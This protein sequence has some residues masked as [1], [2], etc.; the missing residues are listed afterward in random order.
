MARIP[1][2]T[3]QQVIEANDI[4][5][6]ISGYLP[7]LK[8]SG[9]AFKACC[10]FH[11]EKTPSFTVN[12]GRQSFKCFGCGEG[13]SVVGF[14]MK[15]E[16]LPFPDA[17][18]KL[19]SRANIIIREEKEDPQA[20]QLRKSRSRLIEIHNQFAVFLHQL[21]L[22]SKES[23]HARDYLNSRGY[24]ADMAKGWKIGWIPDHAQHVFRW[25]KDNGFTA[26]DLIRCGLAALKDETMPNRGIYL[27]FR[28]RLMFPIHNEYG[29]VI[30]F[31]GRQLRE[32][33]RSGKYVNSPE[34]E[35]FI[36]SKV[37]FGLDKARRA[38]AKQGHAL[39]CEG[40]LDVIAC[41]EAGIET[42]VA[43]Q[44]TA[45]TPDHIR[46]LKRYTKTIILCYDADS[47]GVK[48][49]QSAFIECARAGLNVKVITL[50]EGSDPDT[51]LKSDGTEAFQEKINSA[52]DFFDYKI[53]SSA[54]QLDLNSPSEKANFTAEIASLLTEM[55]DPLQLNACIDFAATRIGIPEEEL[56]KVSQNQ[57]RF[58][59]NVPNSKP[60]EEQ[61]YTLT[62]SVPIRSLCQL[63]LYS[64]EAYDWMQEQIEPL[65]DAI[66][67]E[68]GREALEHLIKYQ[69][70]PV[71]SSQILSYLETLPEDLR[72]AFTQLS[73]E[74][75]TEYAVSS[76]QE[77]FKHLSVSNLERELKIKIQ[78]LDKIPDQSAD[79]HTL[80]KEILDL[81]KF[82]GEIR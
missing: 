11:S 7:D 67:R 12:P 24:G 70:R 29:D 47:A 65:F 9:S 66:E 14:V 3:I 34:T 74:V 64:P 73:D 2:E 22:K 36:K 54:A 15:H 23:Q 51:Y 1:E 71:K 72:S 75:Q 80:Q 26:K 60:E 10:P 18:R 58:K 79:L 55:T 30:G 44:G 16:N 81:Q 32:D 19:A 17:V 38:I 41:H 77:I 57:K 48:A 8:R 49:T 76:A 39:L 63:S 46:I 69:P 78:K 13:G 6:V 28:D 5:E 53:A 59:R 21:L 50:P 56:R 25:A 42:A 35:I 61:K 40:Q 52:R 33:P 45:C 4:I 20:A 82:L 37:I 43:T 62:L 27:R 68:P 31:S